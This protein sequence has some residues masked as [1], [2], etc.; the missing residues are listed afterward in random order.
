MT[1]SPLKD[2]TSAL[3]E[4]EQ[5]MLKALQDHRA[6]T[7]TAVLLGVAVGVGVAVWILNSRKPVTDTDENGDP[8]FV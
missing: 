3:I 1:E 5:R 6:T 7:I 8:L 4:A 2:A